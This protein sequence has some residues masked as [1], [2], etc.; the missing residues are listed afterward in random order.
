MSQQMGAIQARLQQWETMEQSAQDLMLMVRMT[1]EEN[2]TS[3]DEEIN[4]G[5]PGPGRNAPPNPPGRAGRKLPRNPSQP[6]SPY[7]LGPAELRPRTGPAC[8]PACTPHGPPTQGPQRR[9]WTRTQETRTGFAPS[10]SRSTTHSRHSR[11]NT[12]STGWSGFPPSTRPGAGRHH[13]PRSKSC[14]PRLSNKNPGR[15]PAAKSGWRHSWPPDQAVRTSTSW[16]P[17]CA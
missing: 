2:S 13:G 6:S 17:P 7:G 8:F 11:M 14:R 15:S 16:P 12:V 3:L 9:S 10:R 4:Q 5:R 1:E